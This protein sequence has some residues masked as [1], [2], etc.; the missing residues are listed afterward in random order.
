MEVLKRIR[1]NMVIGLLCLSGIA[2]V[3]ASDLKPEDCKEILLL[4]TGGV[5]GILTKLLDS[6]AR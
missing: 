4:A 5:I 1:P 6:D 3:A 2:W